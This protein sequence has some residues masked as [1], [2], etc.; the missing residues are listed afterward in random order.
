ML[1]T[2][3]SDTW[4]SD[5]PRS[6]MTLALDVVESLYG[7]VS[8]EQAQTDLLAIE[9]E[10]GAALA[11][12]P[13]PISGEQLVRVLYKVLGFAGDWEQF[14]S[15]DNCLLNRV[16]A[17]RRGI[18]I[19]LAIVILHFCERF[20]IKAQGIGFP[21]NFLVKFPS[22]E[23][24]VIV[25]PFTGT[26]VSKLDRERLLKGARGN[27]ATLKPI[28][29]KVM[30]PLAMLGRLLNVTKASFIHHQQFDMALK[31][32]ELLLKITPDDPFE[33]RDRGFLY[34]Q[35]DCP[36]W[37]QDDFEFFIEQCPEDPVSEVLKAQIMGLNASPT[38]F[39]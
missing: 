9:T 33:R 7:I 17:R 8:R 14:F 24:P 19:S 23:S 27:L 18:P 39:H 35:L 13:A 22:A 37:A 31:S 20:N 25:N 38:V 3:I 34:E 16:I 11:E 4:L 21:G 36:Q 32:C 26:A 5:A 12:Y 6:I 10:L 2:N 29:M 15:F 1:K 30:T 28:H